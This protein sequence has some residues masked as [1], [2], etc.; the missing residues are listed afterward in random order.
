MSDKYEQSV[1]VSAEFHGTRIDRYLTGQFPNRSRSYIQR[2]IGNGFVVLNNKNVQKQTSIREG[3]HINIK[4]PEEATQLTPDEAIKLSILYEDTDILVL[5]KQVG[6][7]VHPGAGNPSGTLVNGLLAYDYESFSRLVDEG[8]RPGIVH[9]LDKDT[10]GAMVVAKNELARSRLI[11]SFKT[12]TVRKTYLAWVHG[13]PQA[14]PRTVRSL[15]GRNPYSRKKMAVV[16]THGKAAET[17]YES[18]ISHDDYSLIKV[19]IYSGRTHQIRVHMAH[20]GIPIIGDA[21]YGKTK[22]ERLNVPRQL[23]HAWELKFPHPRT[24]KLCAFIAP[25]PV[26]FQDMARRIG[27]SLDAVLK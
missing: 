12:N 14:S 16:E 27:V 19:H 6:L 23:L 13:C 17:Q 21:L 2:L 8:N 5:D 3:D 10:S 20:V 7:I 18:L 24:N 15:V 11:S 1:T 26:D 25:T 22:L 4:W 9:R